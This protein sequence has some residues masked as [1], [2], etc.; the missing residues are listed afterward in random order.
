MNR[1]IDH[2]MRDI[3]RKTTEDLPN[4]R[5]LPTRQGKY[6]G[7]CERAVKDLLTVMAKMREEYADVENTVLNLRYLEGFIT[8][9]DMEVSP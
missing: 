4:R 6:P 5:N 1:E 8:L 9:E 3:R 2:M 7:Y